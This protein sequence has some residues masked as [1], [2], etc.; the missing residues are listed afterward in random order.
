MAYTDDITALSPDHLWTF[1]NI[2]T[3]SVGT[4]DFTSSLFSTTAICRD[5]THSLTTTGT[6]NAFAAPLFDGLQDPSERMVCLW[7]RFSAIQGPPTLIYREGGT[8]AGASLI[9]WAGNNIMFQVW[10]D[11]NAH[12]VQIYCNKPLEINRN[13]HLAFSF[14]D[15]TKTTEVKFYIDGVEQT[16]S[17]ASKTLLTP[18]TAYTGNPAFG[19]TPTGTIHVGN[20]DVLL[21]APVVGYY[22]HMCQWWGSYPSY[23]EFY[24]K[25]FS[26][27]AIPQYT[28]TS[29]TEANMQSQLDVISTTGGYPLGILV[30]EVLGGG[31][32]SLDANDIAFDETTSCHIRYDGTGSLTW[33]N[34][35]TSNTVTYGGNVLIVNPTTI[36]IT[37]LIDGSE[38]RIYDDEVPDDG[39]FNTELSGVESNIGT[40]YQYSHD[41]SGNTVNIQVIKEGYVEINQIHT[42]S[43]TSETLQLFPK[44]EKD[45]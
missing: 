44:V 37:G 38:V 33:T 16:S 20:G 12:M 24:D 27:G 32:L 22:S 21:V 6:A 13:Y 43:S 9:L 40:T 5:S 14:K 8:T 10:D 42:L 23:N 15:T 39:N 18:M 41:G 1:N 31:N 36:T 26:R 45:A 17:N 28:I 4:L 30:E 34:L 29:N 7:V 25:V 11:L 19:N 35:G 3:D 2:A